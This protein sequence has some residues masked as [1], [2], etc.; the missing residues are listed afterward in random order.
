MKKA[1]KKAEQAQV[2]SKDVPSNHQATKKAVKKRNKE[3]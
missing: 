1:V 2:K 3:V